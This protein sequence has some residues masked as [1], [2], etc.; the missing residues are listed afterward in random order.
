MS[1]RCIRRS[2]GQRG[3]TFF[4]V[5]DCNVFAMVKHMVYNGNMIKTDGSLNA[6]VR[7]DTIF[8]CFQN[9]EN[10][11]VP[12]WLGCLCALVL[13]ASCCILCQR[14][15]G[16][17]AGV[18][19]G[20]SIY[21]LFG[22]VCNIVGA[23]LSHQLAIQVK[24]GVFM[25]F[26]DAV[27]VA[28]ILLPLCC[29]SSAVR[30]QRMERRRRRQNQTLQ[31]VSGLVLL[32]CGGW[33]STH[34]SLNPSAHSATGRRLLSDLVQDQTAVLGYVLGLLY[35]VIA[36]TS[37]LPVLSRA[38][39]G[40]VLC[41]ARVWSGVLCFLAGVLYSSAVLVWV[42]ATLPWHGQL[43]AVL[44]ALP[45]LMAALGSAALEV[46]ILA[47]HWCRRGPSQ[48]CRKLSPYTEHLLGGSPPS[49]PE[50]QHHLGGYQGVT[51]LSGS[52]TSRLGLD[53]APSQKKPLV[54]M[55]H[56]MDVDIQPVR[57]M[58]LKQVTLS[59]EK[60]T[61]CRPQRTTERV[62][63][64]DEACTESD[65]S[66]DSSLSYD[67]QWDFEEASPRW[68]RPPSQENVDKFPLQQWPQ[69]PPTA[70]HLPQAPSHLPQAPPT[71]TH[72][73]QQHDD[74][75]REPGPVAGGG[76]VDQG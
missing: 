30:R 49:S 17:H 20:G 28:A 65:S 33:L 5:A 63:R 66:S 69:G 31:A 3:Q 25:V 76:P 21:C 37:K 56:Y 29:N 45:W 60:V 67:L 13:L 19:A 70:T 7:L 73:P 46:L 71:S 75:S 51:P 4:L 74:G 10:V 26:L 59:R 55:G 54:D 36:W 34:L 57:K 18:E 61:N 22:N 72:L 35:L 43:E 2:S 24:L 48:K 58:C 15:R 8:S 52:I 64:V 14:V 39:R 50:T 1:A 38:H 68:S 42:R 40:E 6:W 53:R 32:G 44:A 23:I 62:V 9:N 12:I 16:R 47:V 27:K 11:C 41:R